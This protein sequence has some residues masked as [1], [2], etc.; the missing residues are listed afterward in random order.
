MRKSRARLSPVAI[1][2]HSPPRKPQGEATRGKTARNRLR[3]VDNFMVMYDPML[4]RR[5]EGE[6]AHAFFVDL[7]YG[8]EPVT[9]LESARRLRRLNPALPVLGVEIAPERVAAALPYADQQTDFRLGGFNLP[10]HMAQ[11]GHPERARAIRAFNVLRQY[12]EDAVA[13][14]YRQMC[15]A[16][17]PGGL[18]LEG[19]SD[20][21]G[22]IWVANVVRR[23]LEVAE[24]YRQ[25]ALV[26]SLNFRAG[27]DPTAFQAVLPKNLI[28]QMVPD[29]PIYDFFQAW[30][31][32]TLETAATQV[33][34]VRHWFTASAGRLHDLGYAVN[35]QKRWL[36]RGYLIWQSN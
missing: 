36:S 28:H 18:L 31:Q 14:A 22:R 10:L 5:Q 9:T 15:R 13:E 20:P 8:S 3:R 16:L 4:F 21:H 6:F 11:R 29:Q 27:F 19:T 24:S 1:H 2:P 26:F 32:A 25:E 34:G 23:T 33:W 17:V 12:E 7:G 35:T 30:K